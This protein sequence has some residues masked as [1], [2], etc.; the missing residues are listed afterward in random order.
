[1]LCSSASRS[2]SSGA[3][4]ALYAGVYNEQLYKTTNPLAKA[5]Q[6]QAVTWVKLPTFIDCHNLTDI[7]VF[8]SNPNVILAFE[9]G[10]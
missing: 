10:G 6:V 9:G 8:P 7:Q 5:D 1:M 3:S 2:N 4:P